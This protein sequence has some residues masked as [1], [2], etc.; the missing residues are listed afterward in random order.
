MVA[1]GTKRTARSRWITR[2]I[3]SRSEWAVI[4]EPGRIAVGVA[5]VCY[6]RAVGEV[7]V[8]PGQ[9]LGIG[10]QCDELVVRCGDVDLNGGARQFAQR[11]AVPLAGYPV[12][13]DP[14]RVI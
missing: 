10:V 8:H 13:H 4:V 5:E 6:P 1:S 7:D 14:R 9:A 3:W 2:A 11:Q 12:V